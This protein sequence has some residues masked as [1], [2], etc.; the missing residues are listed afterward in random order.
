MFATKEE[1]DDEVHTILDLYRRIYEEL[2][3]VPVI[4]V[5]LARCACCAELCVLSCAC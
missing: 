5:R 4:K 3:A 1:A 2:L